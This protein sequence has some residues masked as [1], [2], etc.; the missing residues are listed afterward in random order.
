MFFKAM[1]FQHETPGWQV[2][3]AGQLSRHGCSLYQGPQFATPCHLIHALLCSN[4]LLYSNA[5]PHVDTQGQKYYAH[6]SIA[7]SLPRPPTT[8]LAILIA[9][10]LSL[11]IFHCNPVRKSI[12]CRLMF[13]DIPRRTRRHLDSAPLEVMPKKEL[14]LAT[15]SSLED[16]VTIDQH[17]VEVQAVIAHGGEPSPPHAE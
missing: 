6:C 14:S 1:H 17:G 13:G 16:E 3:A 5:K 11:S 9:R 10:I 7:C 15:P 4:A 12:M 8:T 2:S